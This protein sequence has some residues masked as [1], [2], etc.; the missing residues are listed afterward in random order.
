MNKVILVGRLT[1][2]PESR[3]ESVTVFTLA[4]NRTFTKGG[5][6]DQATDFISCV[7]LGKQAEFV[8]TYLHKGT[9]IILEGRIQT[10]SYKNKAGKTVY[11]TDV[12]AENIEFAESKNNAAQD[13]YAFK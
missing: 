8:N 1:K 7:A 5:G 11:T 4:V 9:K 10:G 12:A 2:D 6:N 13:D 3:S